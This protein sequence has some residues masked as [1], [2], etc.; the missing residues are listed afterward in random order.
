MSDS[1]RA[2][3]AR[4]DLIP[5][6]PGVYL[7]KD[8]SGSIIY[9]GKANCLPQRL[10]SYFCPH[11]Q[12][13]AKVLAMISHIADFEVVV[14]ANELEALIL[15][16]NLIK[17]H[18]PRYNILLRDDKEYPYLK[19]TM[20]EAYPRLLK[21]FHIEKDRE[22]GVRYFGPYQGGDLFRALDAIYR[23]FPLK[24]CRRVLPRDIGKERPCLNYYIGRCL[25]PCSGE[26]AQEAYYAMCEEIC[27]F[28]EGRS[29][30]ISKDLESKMRE[31]SESLEFEKAAN[32]RDRLQALNKLHERQVIA[33]PEA[34]AE[35]DVLGLA[36]NNSEIALQILKVREGRI[37]STGCYFFPDRGEGADEIYRAFLTQYYDSGQTLPKEIILSALPAEEESLLEWLSERAGRKLRLIAAERG[38][39]RRWLEMA[40]RNAAESL[41]RHTLMGSNVE[42]REK[43]LQELADFLGMEQLPKRI[44][45][46]DIANTGESDRAA[47]MIVFQ[48]GKPQRTAYRHFKIKSFEGQDDFASMREVL[49][50]RLAHLDEEAF[51][52][53]PQL[54]L[55]DGGK[56]QM[57]AVQDLFT[58]AAPDIELA[59]MVKDER[60][61]SRALLRKD[62][63]M[64]ELRPGRAEEER[65]TPQERESR[66]RLL[67]LI[68]AIQGEAHRFAGRLNRKMMKKRNLR[69]SLEEIPGIGPARRKALL[70][71]F[72]SLKVLA[73][74]DL[75]EIKAV[76]GFPEKAALACYQ[77]FHPEAET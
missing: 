33:F 19:L 52:S 4:L 2:F 46:Y 34:D 42:S 21:S 29:D 36:R 17:L 62:R 39:K 8:A 69:W 1:R 23:I 60:H 49:E 25:G 43:A 61:R 51:G 26:V 10:R 63:V 64:L 53:R 16:N 48:D 70:K 7:M 9:V 76:P 38:R 15:E 74:A 31:A 77:F 14:C 32:Y 22:E 6:E 18:Q 68:T 37:L 28:L 56:G 40:E 66:L 65:L 20:N 47:S 45:A 30:Q 3:D 11:P 71:H 41:L 55:V 72:K 35:D 75:E 27:R 50:R 13:T 67:R 57:S 54:V 58:R 12:G 59:A 24:T 44:E 5:Q 73:E